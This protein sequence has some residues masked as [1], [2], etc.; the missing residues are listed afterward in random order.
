[1]LHPTLLFIVYIYLHF[2]PWNMLEHEDIKGADYFQNVP[3]PYQFGA[4]YRSEGLNDEEWGRI[5]REKLNCRLEQ[6]IAD[7]NEWYLCKKYLPMLTEI[8]CLC[9][10]DWQLTKRFIHGLDVSGAVTVTELGINDKKTFH[11]NPAVLKMFFCHQI[12][13]CYTFVWNSLF[14]QSTLSTFLVS[15]HQFMADSMMQWLI[16]IYLFYVWQFLYVCLKL[17]DNHTIVRSLFLQFVVVLFRKELLHI[18]AI[19]SISE[20]L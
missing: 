18:T 6:P 17:S 5:K 13:I 12:S 10:H 20:Y 8:E 7:R 2:T 14:V 16:Y 9:W 15:F 1:M 3:A 19:L 11:I 4:E